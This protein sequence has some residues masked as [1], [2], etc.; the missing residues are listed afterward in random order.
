MTSESGADSDTST[1]SV[2]LTYRL[3]AAWLFGLLYG[4][5]LFLPILAVVSLIGAAAATFGSF[6]ASGWILLAGILGLLSVSIGPALM[7]RYLTRSWRR[8]LPIALL[9]VVA[10]V[11]AFVALYLASAPIEEMISSTNPWLFLAVLVAL[12]AA[13]AI[14]TIVIRARASPDRAWG[15]L[16]VGLLLG[17][18][19]AV[20]HSSLI[21]PQILQGDNTLHMTWQV[22][23]IVWV[24]AV[25]FSQWPDRP[26]RWRA[27]PVWALLAL[28]SFAM[29]FF[30]FPLLQALGLAF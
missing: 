13:A 16:G 3:L 6:S 27:L 5:G 19:L 2:G 7:S 24:S 1:R 11:I 20:V 12:S 8:A 29:P 23:P 18:G 17:L 26:H 10:G 9:A 21:A 15:G 22:P 28:V 4:I 25:F 14:A 30:S